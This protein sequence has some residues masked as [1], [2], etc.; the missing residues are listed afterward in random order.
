MNLS[1]TTNPTPGGAHA[2]QGM[3]ITSLAAYIKRQIDYAVQAR[4]MNGIDDRLVKCLFQYK[5]K[6]TP[7]KLQEIKEY[8]G[9]EVYIKDTGI[10]CRAAAASITDVYRTGKFLNLEPTPVPDLPEEWTMEIKRRAVNDVIMMAI[11]EMG[12]DISTIDA[13]SMASLIQQIGQ[14]AFTEHAQQIREEV[15][16]QLERR[17][18]QSARLMQKTIEDQL[19]EIGFLKALKNAIINFCIY[20]VAYIKGPIP[21]TAPKLVRRLTAN[22]WEVSVEPTLCWHWYAPSPFNIY[23]C[24]DVSDV[25]DG[26]YAEKLQLSRRDLDEMRGVDGVNAEMVDIILGVYRDRGRKVDNPVDYLQEIGEDRQAIADPYDIIEGYEFCGSVSGSI[27]R[28]W[29]MEIDDTTIQN[30]DTAQ[31]EITARM[32]DDVVFYARINEDPLGRRKL[33]K[34]S[35][36]EVP[37]SWY[38][39]SP[40]ELMDD[41]QGVRNALA[42]ALCNNAAF[43]SGPII[44][45]DKSRLADGERFDHPEPLRVIQLKNPH[46]YT[47]D[48]LQFFQA[49]PLFESIIN[50]M[51]YF[52][53]LSDDGTGIPA[54]MT[55]DTRVGGAGRT[56]GGLFTLMDHAKLLITLA[57]SNIDANFIEQPAQYLYDQNMLNNPDQAIKGDMK[58]RA[59]GVLGHVIKATKQQALMLFRQSLT[60]LDNQLIGM[61]GR[62]RIL[63]FEAELNGISDLVGDEDEMNKRIAQIQQMMMA[64]AQQPESQGKVAEKKKAKPAEKPKEIAA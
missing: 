29:G 12:I 52:G 43:A 49:N 28:E 62:A 5:G 15:D 36:M 33:H 21:Y 48:P 26:Y 11:T 45:I 37:N 34:A 23:P 41:T 60:D 56:M 19:T 9:S 7:E 39:M 18:R 6:Y 4:Q 30:P 22:G 64:Q 3:A 63:A 32:V 31:F 51:I 50:A 55:G 46:G 17:A 42:R 53:R 16:F 25:S 14:Q 8:G 44:G 13:G 20:P 58:I 38:G 10:K 57:I 54:Y 24:P 27:L 1:V 35:Y 47:P 59:T 40:P 61:E 2:N